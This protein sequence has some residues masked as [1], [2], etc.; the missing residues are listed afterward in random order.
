MI[1]NK[2]RVN[3]S[4]VIYKDRK[5]WR[6]SRH[7]IDNEIHELKEKLE[8]L[9]EIRRHL[10]HT[11]PITTS[12]ID[13]ENKTRIDSNE[14]NELSLG[15]PEDYHN[16][17]HHLPVTEQTTK[18]NSTKKKRKRLHD[19]ERSTKKPKFPFEDATHG[20]IEVTTSPPLSQHPRRHYHR[21]GTTR[22]YED[23]GVYSEAATEGKTKITTTS[24]K[25]RKIP[26]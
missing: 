6:Q 16:N 1:I 14:F 26:I 5:T 23:S 12:P 4:T 25:V 15:L 18:V 2:G 9:K 10:K 11:K 20:I 13:G 22:G 24:P 8:K 7:Q 19:L 21:M 17:N 3:C